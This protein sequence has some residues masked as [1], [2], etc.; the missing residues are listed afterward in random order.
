MFQF[1]RSLFDSVKRIVET[2]VATL[3]FGLLFA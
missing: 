1:F 3:I 2:V